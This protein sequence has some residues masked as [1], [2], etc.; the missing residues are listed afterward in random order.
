MT[1]T[2]PIDVDVDDIQLELQL[3]P[4]G[5]VDSVVD[6]TW[7]IS[8][9]FRQELRELNI[10][11]PHLLLVIVNN[12]EEMGRYVV[13]LDLCKWQIAFARSGTNTVFA[14]VVWKEY[15]KH[16]VRRRLMRRHDSGTFRLRVIATDDPNVQLLYNQM[17]ETQQEL[18]SKRSELMN[19]EDVIHPEAIVAPGED[20]DEVT[21]RE[22]EIR[23][24]IAQLE[25]ELEDL[26]SDEDEEGPSREEQI[27]ALQAEIAVLEAE[28]EQL[29][30]KHDERRDNPV[31]EDR[32]LDNFTIADYFHL[33][34]DDAVC[35]SNRSGVLQV[36]VS[37]QMFAKK[38]SRL[39]NWLGTY[40]NW[41][42]PAR[43]QC[44][45]RRRV[46][47]TLGTAWLK[48][49]FILVAG[50]VAETVHLLFTGALLIGGV[51]NINYEV[52]RN[53]LSNV[54]FELLE[55][56]NNSFWFFKKSDE[57]WSGFERRPLALCFINPPVFLGGTI[58]GLIAW[59]FLDQAVFVIIGL[60]LCFVLGLVAY[61]VESI[62]SN[63][64]TPDPEAERAKQEAD[65][66]AREAARKAELD[67]ILGS[68]T[69]GSI[70]Q[71]TRTSLPNHRKVRYLAYTAKAKVCKPFA[72]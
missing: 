15:G 31:R 62:V 33:D 3:K 32:L 22:H 68:V 53:P 64:S 35:R 39:W 42:G 43:D 58:L 56:S 8:P 28:Y 59:V 24:A 36:E 34:S 29:R 19:L 4:G 48:W 69:C 13:P 45:L 26:Q 14:T 51:R 44:Q 52:L 55:G 18:D 63:R 72:R 57:H 40:Y 1:I 2:E 23:V 11:D 71:S 37:A 38:P 17:C 41:P 10:D 49:L 46:L 66:A 61:M 12:H 20:A 9:R 65:R 50:F 5:Q 67:R 6:I 7:C 70:N 21:Q 30:A 27:D 54:P 47:F 25:A 16:D 60:S